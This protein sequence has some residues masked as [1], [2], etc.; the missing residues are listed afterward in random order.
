[1]KHAKN[2]DYSEEK[3]VNRGLV[4][5]PILRFLAGVAISTVHENL[6]Q[7]RCA[8]IRRACADRCDHTYTPPCNPIKWRVPAYGCTVRVKKTFPISFNTIPFGLH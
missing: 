4:L 1:M 2:I 6:V 7:A 3:K 8:L 5:V